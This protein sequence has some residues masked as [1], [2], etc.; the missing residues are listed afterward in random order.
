[1]KFDLAIQALG[2]TAWDWSEPGFASLATTL[3]L[4]READAD[5]EMPTYESLWG[6]EWVQAIVESGAVARVEFLVEETAPRWRPFPTKK[7]QA[8]GRKY[9]DKL[10][11]YVK[12]AS[13]ALGEPAFYGDYGTPGWPDDEDGHALALWRTDTARLIVMARNAGPD[14]PFWISIVVKPL[15]PSRAQTARPSRPV[16]R[17]P[18]RQSTATMHGAR[19]D[20]ALDTIAS[21][22]W[23]W[24][25]LGDDVLDKLAL[26]ATRDGDRVE[27]EVESTSP[28][29][30]GFSDDDMDDLD[31]DYCDKYAAYVSRATR[32]LGKPKFND[33]M[34][35]KAFPKDEPAELLALWPLKTARV[36]LLY[37]NDGAHVPY[38]ISLVVK[39]R[40]P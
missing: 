2:T 12:R 30:E 19:F 29:S 11:A 25:A 26:P 31:R 17:A 21:V 1:M 35:H 20:A 37:T 7:L 8:L 27:L 6:K 40:S 13:L 24:S 36:M 32:I 10:A 3:G 38:A 18:T 23:D 28:P 22:R 9:R 5:P 14:T 39:P 4:S 16:M 33:G 34:G 15:A